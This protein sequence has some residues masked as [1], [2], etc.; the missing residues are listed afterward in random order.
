MA[1]LPLGDRTAL[2]HPFTRPQYVVTV[3]VV[4]S[5]SLLRRAL[6]LRPNLVVMVLSVAA[7]VYGLMP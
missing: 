3:K 1:G 6:A 4:R 5:T 7:I 2:T